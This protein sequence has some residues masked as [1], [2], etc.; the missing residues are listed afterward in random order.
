MDRE[1]EGRL[2]LRALCWRGLGG[3]CRCS[4][5]H[6]ASGE[7]AV[8]ELG[9]QVGGPGPPPLLAGMRQDAEPQEVELVLPA[10]VALFGVS[11]FGLWHV[12]GPCSPRD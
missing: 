1:G 11:R 3:C 5:L 10:P 9:A 8:E 4:D 2:S 6:S 12:D 7:A